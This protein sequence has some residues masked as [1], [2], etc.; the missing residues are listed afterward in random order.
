MYFYKKK[1]IKCNKYKMCPGYFKSFESIIMK[2]P[3]S[4][5]LLNFVLTLKNK[6][7]IYFLK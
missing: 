7:I 3:A 4:P 5:F 2:F 1:I 6:Y